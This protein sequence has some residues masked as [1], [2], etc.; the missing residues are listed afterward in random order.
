MEEDT[1]ISMLLWVILICMMVVIFRARRVCA[2]Q[3]GEMADAWLLLDNLDTCLCV[4]RLDTGEILYANRKAR[5]E[6]GL[7]EGTGGVCWEIFREGAESSCKNCPKHTGDLNEG[8]YHI[9][10]N[11][12]SA[13]KKYY[14]NIDS[15]VTW[16]GVQAHMRHFVDITERREAEIALAQNK[17][18]LEAALESSRHKND[19]KSEFLSRMSHEIRTPMNAVIGMTKIAKQSQD[20]ATVKS[21]LDNID[22]SAKQLMAIINDIF[23]VSKIE[24]HKL[25][26]VNASFNFK[27]TMSDA[28][29]QF[30]K[31][32]DDK[33]QQFTFLLDNTINT[34]YIGDETRLSQVVSNLLSNAVKFTPEEGRIVLSARQKERVE[35]KVT[36][37][38]SISDSGIG[39]SKENI[40]KLFSPFEQLDGSISRK[41][42][43]T[44]L[45]LVLSKNI[46][47]LM[48][49]EFDVKS[50]EGKGSTFAFT[51][52]L[53]IGNDIPEEALKTNDDTR[54]GGTPND[55][56]RKNSVADDSSNK[57]V[58]NEEP[59]MKEPIPEKS[60]TVES[61]E[62]HASFD[63]LL[64]FINVKR[65]LENL[66]GNEKLYVT[67]LKSYQK[68]DMLVKI[69]DFVSAVNFRE[70]IHYAQALKSITANIA[71]DDLRTK[72]E[73]LEES[74]RSL[75]SDDILLDK[76]EISTKE[77]RKL[78][79][80]LILALEEG[81]LS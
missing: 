43:G 28:Y 52:K 30:K 31:Q 58:D 61:L 32:A 19:V 26:L 54:E 62:R 40:V 64:P 46:V 78:I 81:K 72:M 21:C 4:S 13:T 66:K 47:E 73:M 71:L 8:S 50:E 67:L 41:Y 63:D 65:G 36:V 15:V 10:E 74:L 14:K 37:E 33:K 5:E 20:E 12:N 6:F 76:L 35:N 56:S 2:E 51:V 3:G 53:T 57:N 44:G 42:G 11:Y 45:G 34:M 79:P 75:M 77:T 16:M 68:N 27:K 18:N 39:I 48:G 38:V 49:G 25:E 70:A 60:V 69:R 24:A 9:W 29:E 59:A 17:E 22:A 23:D 7:K 80:E 55:D 1:T